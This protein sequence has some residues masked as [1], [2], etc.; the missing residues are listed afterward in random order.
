MEFKGT[1][2]V[3]KIDYEDAGVYA[4]HEDRVIEGN[5]ICEAPIHWNE[6]MKLWEANAKLI[7][8][9]PSMLDELIKISST[10]DKGTDTYNRIIELIKK[11]TS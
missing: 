5:I 10:Y 3:W 2:G 9:A 4:E 11:A 6:S 7:A 8:C 1:E